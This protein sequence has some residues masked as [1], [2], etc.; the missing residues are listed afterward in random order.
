MRFSIEAEQ[1]VIGG[2]LLDNKKF[3]DVLEIIGSADFYNVDHKHIFDAMTSLAN[4][5]TPVDVIT[6]AEQM[7]ESG[8]LDVIGGV[9]Y[10]VEIAQNTPSAA[11][12]MS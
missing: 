5:N 4:S 8:T 7:S 1:S 6:V 11:N 9:S 12:I 10:L 2:L 3:D